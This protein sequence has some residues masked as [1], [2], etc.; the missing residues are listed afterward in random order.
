MNRDQGARGAFRSERSKKRATDAIYLIDI[1]REEWKNDDA[2][3]SGNL[4]E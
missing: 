2:R 4:S 3:L 1:L